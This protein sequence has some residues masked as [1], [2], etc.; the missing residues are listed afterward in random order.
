MANVTIDLGRRRFMIVP[1][2]IG[3]RSVLLKLPSKK[4]MQAAGFFMVP[5]TRS[6]ALELI[7]AMDR[8]EIS[9]GGDMVSRLQTLTAPLITDRRFPDWYTFNNKVHPPLPHQREALNYL[10][11]TDY[12]AMFMEMGTCKT[13]IAI[14][15]ATAHY[16]E[17]RIRFMIVICPLT[18]KLSTWV[19]E[20]EQ[21]SPCPYK[22]VSVE[23]NFEA[24]DWV[25]KMRTDTFYW[26]V[27]GIESL[28]QGKTASKLLGLTKLG[29]F[30]A[31]VDESSRIA[32]HK[33]ICTI[34]AKE[35]AAAAQIRVIMT[36]SEIKKNIIDLY[37]Q[38]DYLD[39][40]IIGAGDYFAFRNRYC[41][42]G[43][44]K[45]KQIEG[46]N[47]IDEL[48]GLIAP[49]V[50]QADKRVLGTELPP[51]VYQRRII[52][53]SP[54]QRKMYTQV[55]GSRLE[56]YALANVLTRT[57]RLQQIT[58]GYINSDSTKIDPVTEKRYKIPVITT[59]IVPPSKNPKLRELLTVASEIQHPMIVWAVS[60]YEIRMLITAL[61]KLGE[62]IV[63]T[64]ETP[65]EDRKG[66]ID[67]FQKGDTPFWVGTAASGGIGTTLT[68]ARTVAYFSNNQ[69]Y[70]DRAQSEDRAHRKGQKYSVNYVDFIAEKTVDISVLENLFEKR[71]ISE[72]VKGML[73]DKIALQ[74]FWDGTLD[75]RRLAAT[76]VASEDLLE[77]SEISS[78]EPSDVV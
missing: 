35:I 58:C 25:G 33:A 17:Q 4:W 49:H 60:M 59:E 52:Q 23:S 38:F 43:G 77:V 76:P 73:R 64:G 15:L 8:G 13:R 51:K 6:N 75:P 50:Y 9:F 30:G 11:P 62:V 68:A 22:F 27:A 26:F 61:S 24:K 66:L 72:Y 63:L 39:P 36:G 32:N 21:Y 16:Y 46:Y 70:I 14:D 40:N 56:G 37:S 44:Y 47:H 1:F 7:Q 34:N 12:A 19:T 74:K 57:L 67:R 29:K 71:D 54:E 2:G 53:L 48:M 5:Q 28:S 31:V 65:K 3:E 45:N 55:K 41:I 18:V 69:R 42:M 10:Y 20:L 78:H